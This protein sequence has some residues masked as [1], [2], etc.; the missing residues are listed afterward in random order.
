MKINKLKVVL[1]VI[2]FCSLAA[3]S[4]TINLLPPIL[5]PA[6]NPHAATAFD[7]VKVGDTTFY[8]MQS[9]PGEMM[10][11]TLAY[12]HPSSPYKGQQPILDRMICLLDSQLNKWYIGKSG[13]L[14]DFPGAVEATYSYLTLKT[15]A[16]EKIPAARKTIWETAI[17]NKNNYM[18]TNS[19]GIFVSNSVG[20]LVMNMEIKRIF[21]VFLGGLCI[22]DAVVA[23]KGKAAMENC[24][25]KNILPDG[26][27]HYVSYSNETMGYHGIIVEMTA[28]YY[29][30][31]GSQ[32][33]KDY[34]F[35][36]K[37]YN[38]LSQ[39]PNGY[40]EFSTAPPWKC[41]YVTKFL[42]A[43]ALMLG[44]F[45]GDGYNYTMGQGQNGLIYPF[46]YKSGV[47]AK[48]LPDNFF[49]YDRNTLGPRSHFGN[50]TAVGTTRDPSSPLPEINETPAPTMCGINTFAGGAITKSDGTLDAAFHGAAPM[51]KYATGVELDWPR[52]QKWGFMTG[53]GIHTSQSKGYEVYGLA[54]N[55]GVYKRDFTN[56]VGW[57]SSQQWVYT[58]DRV[59][60]M[61]EMSNSASSTLFGLAQR[62]VLV[63]YRG[64]SSPGD[65]KAAKL[66]FVDNSTLQY[67]NLRIKI[68]DQN[69]NGK[70]DTTYFGIYNG[71]VANSTDRGSVVVSMNDVQSGSDVAVTY[72]A[73][74]KR[75]ALFEVTYTAKNYSS[76]VARLTASIPAGLEGFEFQESGRKVR[77]I[78]NTTASAIS[79]SGTMTCPFGST[80]VMQS[81][82]DASL[83]PLTVTSGNTSIPSIS[84]PAYGNIVIVNSDN[85][86]DQTAGYFLYDNIFGG[87]ILPPS[88]LKVNS[89]GNA[90]VSLSWNTSTG[91][92]SYNIKRS[93]T[94]GNYTTIA[95]GITGTTF[96]DNNATN[97][98]T[99]YYVVSAVNDTTETINS[100]SVRGVPTPI[101]SGSTFRIN[102]KISDKSLGILAQSLADNAKVQ[103][104]TPTTGTDQQW[105]LTVAADGYYLIKNVN[106]G[107]YL[108]VEN[109]SVTAGANIVQNTANG[110]NSQ[111]W[112][113]FIQPN[114]LAKIT[115]KSSGFCVEISGSSTAIGAQLVQNTFSGATNQ[116]FYLN[117]FATTEIPY[118]SLNI[119]GIIEAENFDV[120]GE[121]ISYHDLDPQN[122][123]GKYRP[124]ESV[125]IDTCAYGGY[126]LTSMKT[127]EWIKYTFNSKF[128]M[129][130]TMSIRASAVLSSGVIHIEIDGV[131]KTGAISITSTGDLQ[132]ITTVSKNI[133]IADGSHVMRIVVDAGDFN[134]DKIV[135]NPAAS[136]P[137]CNLAA[138]S[139]YKGIGV[140]NASL[141]DNTL[142]EQRSPNGSANQQ[143]AFVPVSTN[144]NCKV[145]NMNSGKVIDVQNPTVL[146]GYNY[147][148]QNTFTSGTSTQL[149]N[150][151]SKGSGYYSIQNTT[152]G[153]TRAMDIPGNAIY[154][155][156]ANPQFKAVNSTSATQMFYMAALQFGQIPYKGLAATVPGYFEAEDFDMGGEGAAYH[157]TNIPNIGDSTALGGQYRLTESVD[158]QSTTGGGYNITQTKQ[159]EW[160]EYTLNFPSAGDYVLDAKVASTV[161]SGLFHVDVDGGTKTASIPINSTGGMQTWSTVSALLKNISVG[162][163]QMRFNIDNGGFNIDNFRLRKAQIIKFDSIPKK[164]PNSPDFNLGASVNTGLALTYSSSNTAVATVSAIGL[165]HIA[166]SGTTNITVS[167]AG[168]NSN[169]PATKTWKLVVDSNTN[170]D[171]YVLENC[172]VYPNPASDFV[173]INNSGNCRITVIDMVGKVVLKLENQFNSFSINISKLPTGIYN[174]QLNKDNY[175]INKKL[176]ISR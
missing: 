142:L 124:F 40:D 29:L 164:L 86:N 152:S 130:Y 35:A 2:L 17:T 109:Q 107:K 39:M 51:V 68:Y 45:T 135:L 150:F 78:H 160:L 175:L 83:N 85:S 11:A 28:W 12:F 163:H 71:T 132:N 117:T 134:L 60:G 170:L 168:D 81:W 80:R 38:P 169:A 61:T 27:T 162:I 23:N 146:N 16:P 24:L 66:V 105:V 32:V 102:A 10:K 42:N 25:F 151:V 69:Y 171:Q 30:F 34:L 103:Q 79:Y 54:S 13:D 20:S 156:G 88:G 36:L 3:Q 47:K 99:Y 26:G 37:N 129:T 48:P 120:G 22:N 65:G 122:T 104:F 127:G 101:I 148:L 15:Y 67:G 74:T 158:I 21:A 140:Q 137:I 56:S 157:D 41:Q 76:N 87:K 112:F 176:I 44:Y 119:P 5:E 154:S 167:Q 18:I 141:A 31:T 72:P 128:P 70:I 62:I 6:T 93:T 147:L 8:G 172:I 53:P 166:G 110:L 96:T 145:V 139:S 136:N 131:D 43:S 33:A 57:N 49:V 173:K 90:Q 155:D 1:L 91:A 174:L 126:A 111:L 143:W 55:Y 59:I 121:G 115:N 118:T 161:G 89:V 98:I 84:I 4:Q 133:D 58:P 125:D 138:K 106:S 75:Y 82:N 95:S 46:L 92:T 153:T 64:T 50:W 113:V 144:G 19:P 7:G 114:G 116:F 73:G 108:D 159:G 123:G 100:S 63:S 165:I 97:C 149:W 94:D 9:D 77:M 52:G 14:G